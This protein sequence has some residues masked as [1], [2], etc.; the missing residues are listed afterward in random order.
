MY[1]RGPLWRVKTQESH[2]TPEPIL[3]IVSSEAFACGLVS[4][5]ALSGVRNA[6]ALVRVRQGRAGGEW[7]LCG[8]RPHYRSWTLGSFRLLFNLILA[9]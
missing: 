3:R 2:R 8:F 6:L 7:L 1:D 5:N 9:P 4:K